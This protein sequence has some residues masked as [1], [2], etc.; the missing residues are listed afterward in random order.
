MSEL[1]ET[2]KAEHAT[3]GKVLGMLAGA[4]IDNDE[5]RRHLEAAK[6]GLLAHLQR[7]DDHLYPALLE[8]AEDDPIFADALEFFEDDIA[9]VATAA[10]AFFA[11]YEDGGPGG[12]FEADFAA[13]A[14]VLG[15]R[16]RKE[17][18]VLYQLYEKL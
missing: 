3:I 4:G 9:G 12:D 15:Q 14:G 8:A 5:G 16:I 6:A 17:E 7:E 10:L 11:K 18:S 1:I 2:L 13:L